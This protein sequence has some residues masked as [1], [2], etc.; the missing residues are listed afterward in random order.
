L[1]AA[2]LIASAL[3]IKRR[4]AAGPRPRALWVVLASLGTATGYLL[5]PQTWPG[6]LGAVTIVAASAFLL[7]R[8]GRSPGWSQRHILAVAAGPVI[9]MALFAFAVT[10]LGDIPPVQKYA[11]NLVF[12][13]GSLALLLWAWRRSADPCP[14]Q[15]PLPPP[16]IQG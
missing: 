9:A 5:L 13:L 16:A 14:A 10:P 2:A 8:A 11:H 3:V 15:R 12:L 6:F 7:A 1:V 4:V